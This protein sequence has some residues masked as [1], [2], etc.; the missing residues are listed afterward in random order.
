MA[1]KKGKKKATKRRPPEQPEETSATTEGDAKVTIGGGVHNIVFRMPPELSAPPSEV[2]GVL[3][4]TAARIRKLTEY[5]RAFHVETEAGYYSHTLSLHPATRRLLNDVDIGL[6]ERNWD[7]AYEARRA[8]E[9]GRVD[10]G[11]PWQ[12]AELNHEPVYYAGEYDLGHPAN[13]PLVAAAFPPDMVV[14]D[15]KVI[16]PKRV[17]VYIRPDYPE[18]GDW[19]FRWTMLSLPIHSWFDGATPQPAVLSGADVAKLEEY[20]AWS[21][22]FAGYIELIG[23]ERN[24]APGRVL[25]EAA[26]ER[27]REPVP[28]E[29]LPDDVHYRVLRY[30]RDRGGRP[31]KEQVSDGVDG[32]GR[33]LI[34]SAISD[35]HAWKWVYAPPQSRKGVSLLDAGREALK[36]EE[37]RLKQPRGD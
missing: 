30:L 33:H 1:G 20:A 13:A 14:G 23:G 32:I 26:L 18:L 8:L 16:W 15:A 24:P 22:R 11:R 29:P 37:S 19:F 25:T 35:M 6:M 12:S 7:N 31:T 10:Q 21:E 9:P 17:H 3:R 34:R 28:T 27:L 2:A 4:R 5:I 36:A